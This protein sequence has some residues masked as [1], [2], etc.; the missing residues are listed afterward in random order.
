MST[1]FFTIIV[2]TYNASATIA[3]CI[4][5]V[6]NQHFKNFE[7]LIM[8]GNSTD[9]TVQIIKS[10]FTQFNSI[11][12]V[13]EKDKGI[14]DAMNKGISLSKP[15]WLYF[16]GGDDKFYNSNVLQNVFDQIERLPEVEI[17]YGNVWSE[18]FNGIYDGEFNYSKILIQNISHQAIFFRKEIFEKTGDFNLKYTAQA[19]WDHNLKW[20]LSDKIEKR[21]IDIIIAYYADGGFSSLNGDDVFYHDLTLNYLLYCRESLS[22]WKK[23]KIFGYELLKAIK[24]GD[25]KRIK[26]SLTF[27]KYV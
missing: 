1:P 23:A 6:M 17:V 10:Y 18:R 27:F 4:E 12:L 15:S 24:N 2:P 20:I 8:D 11:R 14:Y 5:S 16:M 7:L 3:A 22:F 19:D 21:Y 25:A 26:K 13:T 9:T